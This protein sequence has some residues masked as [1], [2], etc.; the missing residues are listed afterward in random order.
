MALSSTSR[1]HTIVTMYLDSLNR[2]YLRTPQCLVRIVGMN[3]T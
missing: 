1:L 2:M 3:L